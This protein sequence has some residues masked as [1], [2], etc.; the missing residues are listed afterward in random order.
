MAPAVPIVDVVVGGQYGSEGKGGVAAHLIKRRRGQQPERQILAVR[1]AGPNAGHS[2]VGI[3]DGHK[4]ALRQIPV[5]AVADLSCD[6]IIAQ[7]SEID[8]AVLEAEVAELDQA[9]YEV[10][11]RLHIDGQATMIQQHHKD[12]E[13]ALTGRLGSTAKGI[14]AARSARIMRDATLAKHVLH[15]TTH[16]TAILHRALTKGSNIII[17]GTQGYGLG[18]HAGDYP[19]CTSS[20]CTAID[21][22]AMAGLYPAGA[23]VHVWVA[24]R[25]YPI[26]VAGNS[27]P[28]YGERNW[29][30][31][32]EETDGYI[33]PER[34]TVTQKIRRVGTWDPMLVT[35]A[36]QANGYR[37]DMDRNSAHLVITF[38]DYIDPAVAGK[39]EYDPTAYPELDRWLTSNCG[40][41]PDAICTGP[42]SIIWGADAP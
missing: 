10:S 30:D 12:S 41:T 21:F 15:D 31:L 32:N 26:R 33:Q 34:T 29:L 8:Q 22:L 37:A 7:G 25:T 19:Y 18:L 23:D 14:G 39:T 24:C 4:Y 5:M 3:L 2:A 38:G 28:L 6:L 20:D 1:V 17:E 42:D 9:G 16:T 35:L 13:V 11:S 36:M 40:I 27:G